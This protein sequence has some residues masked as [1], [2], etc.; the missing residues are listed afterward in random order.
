MLDIVVEQSETCSMSTAKPH[1]IRLA[2]LAANMTQSGL[3]LAVGVTKAS[4]SRWE[5][6]ADQPTPARAK[7]LV[8]VLPGLTL[9]KV[10]A[11]QGRAAA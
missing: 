2:R 11:P 6:G 4:V 1:P 7:D 3:A 5:S 8:R 10:Y 9:E